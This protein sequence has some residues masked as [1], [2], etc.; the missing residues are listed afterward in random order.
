MSI[1]A[2]LK[3]YLKQLRLPTTAKNFARLAEEAQSLKV[4]HLEYLCSL[5]ELEVQH[6]VENKRKEC[7]S[8]AKF[9]TT[10]SLD[11]FQ[12]EEIPA[13]NKALVLKLFGG[14]YLA[15]GE[16]VVLIGG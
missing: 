1:E 3:Q 7:L 16:N 14:Q 2:L 13:L 4:G 9:P 11:S 10:K 15:A 8:D 12:F 6:R 5:L